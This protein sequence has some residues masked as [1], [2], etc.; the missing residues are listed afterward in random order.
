[1]GVDIITDIFFVIIG[2][3]LL[4]FGGEGLVRGSVAV[5]V[6]LGL[7]TLLVSVVIVG[8]GTSVPELLVSL[9]AAFKG[10]PDIALG[11][12][13]GSNIAN[14]LLIL[15]VA[16]LMAPVICNSTDMRRDALVG[17]G[18]AALLGVLS[19]AG[20]LSWY[21]GIMMVTGLTAY[22]WYCYHSERKKAAAAVEA[23]HIQEEFHTDQDSLGKGIAFALGG[24][25]LLAAGAHMLVEGAVSLASAAGV[26]QAVIG[27]TLVAIGTSLPELATA[28]VAALKKHADVVIG[29]VL[30]S[31]LFN[32]LFV[33]GATATI[34]PIP[35]GGRLAEI[36]VWVMLV[37][38]TM[39]FALIAWKGKIGR[40][41]GAGFLAAYLGYTVW[42]F[43]S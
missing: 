42:L 18:A 35:F 11:N 33:L 31:N 37:I 14:V 24:L 9:Q 36:D 22:L 20:Y 8:F 29:N 30:G 38:V 39:L 28:I 34:T 21:A 26:S 7:S 5:A 6:R 16:A 27:L 13:V 25:V 43:V 32:I 17:V 23:E 2:L 4:F 12:V 15:G 1:M 10:T 40:V 19:F 41:T 3:A